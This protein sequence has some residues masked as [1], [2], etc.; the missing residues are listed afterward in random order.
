M[1]SSPNVITFPRNSW[2]CGHR[3]SPLARRVFESCLSKFVAPLSNFVFCHPVLLLSS[4][5]SPSLLLL[6]LFFPS[7]LTRLRFI[8]VFLVKLR[9]QACRP[10]VFGCNL[11]FYDLWKVFIQTQC[12][13]LL[14]LVI[15]C[16]VIERSLCIH[17]GQGLRS[18]WGC[19]AFCWPQK[20]P[21]QL[22]SEKERK[23]NE[24]LDTSH[25]KAWRDMTWRRKRDGHSWSWVCTVDTVKVGNGT[26]KVNM[27]VTT[28]AKGHVRKVER[29]R[30]KCGGCPCDWMCVCVCGWGHFHSFLL[31]MSKKFHTPFHWSKVKFVFFFFFAWHPLVWYERRRRCRQKGR[32]R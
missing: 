2:Q 17:D 30:K 31:N 12:V 29:E 32:K 19:L 11:I 6:L 7:Y 22:I 3:L 23:K 9:L 24:T 14:F 21:S 26:K 13:R 18:S 8:W 27:T 25:V 15:T 20:L 1:I 10:C 16:C 4:P 5:L 28:L